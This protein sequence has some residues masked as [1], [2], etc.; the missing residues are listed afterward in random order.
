[1]RVP[2]TNFGDG[3]FGSWTTSASATYAFSKKLNVAG[4]VVKDFATTAV[5]SFV[6]S[7]SASLDLQY[8]YSSRWALNFGGGVG[9]TDFLGEAG[10]I[11]ISLGP[12]LELGAARQDTFAMAHATLSYTMNEHLRVSVAYNW[13]RNWS[14]S[15]FADFVRNSY[16]LN[17]S[18]R[19]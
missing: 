16:S 7:L 18:T 10:R 1:V 6:D 2:H 11:V 17:L 19:W 15:S 12:P 5:D 3:S 13:F 9:E 8:T 14:K 4:S